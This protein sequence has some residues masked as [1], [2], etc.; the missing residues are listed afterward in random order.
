MPRAIFSYCTGEI[1][2]LDA[3][4]LLENDHYSLYSVNSVVR[5]S[6]DNNHH[7]DTWHYLIKE[8]RWL[9]KDGF[10][11]ADFPDSCEDDLKIV[12]LDPTCVE[13]EFPAD[14][15]R[16]NESTFSLE[17]QEILPFSQQ[18][19]FTPDPGHPLYFGIVDD[20]RSFVEGLRQKYLVDEVHDAK[21]DRV[22][23]ESTVPDGTA[24]APRAATGPRQYARRL[25]LMFNE[26][27]NLEIWEW[28]VTAKGEPT[29]DTPNVS[30]VLI[31]QPKRQSPGWDECRDLEWTY[32]SSRSDHASIYIPD[33]EMLMVHG[34]VGE[35]DGSSPEIRVLEDIWVLNVHSCMHN[36]S[37]HGV[38][39]NGYCNC[40]PG[41]YG[42]DCSNVTCPGSVCEYDENRNQQCVHCCH[43][44][45]DGGRKIDCKVQDWDTMSFSGTSEGICDGFG[46]CQCAPPYIG[47]DCAILDCPHNCS[48]N[49][50]C[51]LEFPRARCMCLDGFVGEYCEHRECLS[52]CSYPNGH[53]NFET[54]E[55]E[56]SKLR[57]PYDR[58]KSW[59]TWQGP[60][61]SYLPV[62]ASAPK[63]GCIF[64]WLLFMLAIIL[65]VKY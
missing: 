42:L 45:A 65:A 49:G 25:D 23:L 8:R 18:P 22:W 17:Y 11:H 63:M 34:G 2:L 14:L 1:I 56:C 3:T 54:G 40:D 58:R 41:F 57:N 7:N 38:C 6:G 61:C 62:F 4:S 10:V 53:C 21:G 48:F 37:G 32:P 27:T 19:G 15:K 24:I 51:S 9:P 28:C 50:Y 47:E 64:L 39:T 35:D 44:V 46:T 52:N 26:T 5:G 55:C 59:S 36:C 13:L 20:G 31:P 33:Y 29:R 12:K 16:S 43:D 30:S 60:D